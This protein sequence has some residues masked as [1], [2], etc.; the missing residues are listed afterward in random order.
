MSE[1]EKDQ[2]NKPLRKDSP[3]RFQPKVL[4]IWLVIIGAILS[5]YLF[6]EPQGQKSQ[7]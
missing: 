5:L 1:E 4:I 6:S 7:E 2:R 3:E